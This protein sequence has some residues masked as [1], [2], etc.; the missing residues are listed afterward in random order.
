MLVDQMFPS[1]YIKAADLGGREVTVTID[2]VEMEDLGS[3]RKPV[4]YFRGK[5]KGLVLNK[6]NAQT[7]A[8]MHGGNTAKW[9]GKQIVLFSMLVSY[10]GEN[11]P[12]IR[13]KL[14]AAGNGHQAPSS[15]YDEATE[16]V[17]DVGD[18]VPF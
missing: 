13:I 9:P 11:R 2:R 16:Y 7:I 15:H 4:V 6:T 3:E 8:H 1:N 14:T 10:Q 12:G 5:E 17:A 18:E